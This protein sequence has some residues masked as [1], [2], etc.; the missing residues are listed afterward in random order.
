V[1][2]R[3]WKPSSSTNWPPA[4][5]T[6]RKVSRAGTP[7]KGKPKCALIGVLTQTRITG[8]ADSEGRAGRSRKS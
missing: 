6:K 7:W 3:F 5:P 8:V 1:G 2:I 4:R